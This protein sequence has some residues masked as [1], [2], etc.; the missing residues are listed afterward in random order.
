MLLMMMN[1]GYPVPDASFYVL[2]PHNNIQHSLFTLH[3]HWLFSLEISDVLT[4]FLAFF[5]SCPLF[6]FHASEVEILQ[7]VMKNTYLFSI[8]FWVLMVTD[9]KS[10]TI[11]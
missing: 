5:F 6:Q 10:Y 3:L 8:Q 11:F 9:L 4:A 7:V 1:Q 2:S